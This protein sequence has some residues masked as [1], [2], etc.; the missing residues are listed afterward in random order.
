ML[1]RSNVQSGRF[2]G[3]GDFMWSLE[4][5]EI[6]KAGVSS[7]LTPSVPS[8]CLSCSVPKRPIPIVMIKLPCF[9]IKKITLLWESFIGNTNTC[10]RNF[11]W[12]RDNFQRAKVVRYFYVAPTYLVKYIPSS[13][14][15]LMEV[16]I[17]ELR[18]EIRSVRPWILS[19]T[20]FSDIFYHSGLN[21]HLCKYYGFA[22]K[23]N[24][25]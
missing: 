16:S 7:L 2:L 19:E 23:S 1:K 22:R 25:M 3:E 10:I 13:E 24:M 21:A 8:C 15:V 20:L 14:S 4:G 18:L 9:P 17:T 12:P 5:S 11:G 6:W